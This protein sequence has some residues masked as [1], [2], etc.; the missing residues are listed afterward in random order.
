MAAA[1][2]VVVEAR[3]DEKS[4]TGDAT[5]G[6]KAALSA[7]L[8]LREGMGVVNDMGRLS[9]PVTGPGEG[10]TPPSLPATGEKSEGDA[11]ASAAVYEYEVSIALSRRAFTLPDWNLTQFTGPEWAP[12]ILWEGWSDLRKS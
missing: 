7:C 11:G 3:R 9:R 4:A 2:D 5:A 8:L 10:N 12:R 6:V 1:R